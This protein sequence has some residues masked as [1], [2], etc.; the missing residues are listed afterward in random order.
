MTE[1]SDIESTI[2]DL[3]G[4]SNALWNFAHSDELTIET[5]YGLQWL[6]RQIDHGMSELRKNW[7][8]LHDVTNGRAGP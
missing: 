5:V 7:N 6:A 1:A 3:E 8:D 2:T 4:A